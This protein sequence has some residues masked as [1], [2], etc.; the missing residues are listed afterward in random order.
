MNNPSKRHH[1]LPEFYL[2]EFT[3]NEGGFYIYDKIKDR[4]DKREKFPKSYFFE[5]DRNTTKINGIENDLLETFYQNVDDKFSSI[6]RQLIHLLSKKNGHKDNIET[7][8]EILIFINSIRWRVP[9]RDFITLNVL[10]NYDYS[11]L[12]YNIIEK[13]TGEI[14]KDEKVLTFFKKLEIFKK[15]QESMI[16]FEPFY[17]S[18]HLLNV[19]RNFLVT[20]QNNYSGLICDN[21]YIENGIS[22]DIKK[23]SEFIFPLTKHYIAIY[24]KNLHEEKLDEQFSL[25]LELAKIENSQ[26]FTACADKEYLEKLVSLYRK[27]VSDGRNKGLISELFRFLKD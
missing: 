2:K 17:N 25:R 12:S 5:W 11:N 24:V 18:K 23:F 10:N 21:P 6:Y 27:I 20:S 22:K 16:V 15:G 7:I 13:K 4:I 9:A 14:V 1:Y 8:N 19:H 26:R 3:N